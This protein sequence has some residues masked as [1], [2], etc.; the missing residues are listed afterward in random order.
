MKFFVKRV[1]VLYIV[2]LIICSVIKGQRLAMALALTIS[3]L[4]ALLRFAVLESVLKH[5]ISIASKKQA[6]FISLV[7]YL[8]NLVI[9]GITVVLAMQFGID[10]LLAALAGTLSILI[11]V[12][13]NAVTEAFG[14]T[15]NHYGQK[16]K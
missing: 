13:I 2:A 7:I 14:I 10:V 11:I 12:M 1:S 4:L 8:L 9:I 15:K 3:V 5:S 16:V 6:I